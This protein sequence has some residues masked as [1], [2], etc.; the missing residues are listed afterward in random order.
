VG[1]EEFLEYREPFAGLPLFGF[2]K[3]GLFRKWNLTT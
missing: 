2:K 3:K 1:D